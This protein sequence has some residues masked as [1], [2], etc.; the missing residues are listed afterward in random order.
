MDGTIR[1][2]FRQKIDP[3]SKTLLLPVH[4]SIPSFG[5]WEV[6]IVVF[7]AKTLIYL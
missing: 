1:L 5:R 6:I 2:D 3:V 4:S 7:G